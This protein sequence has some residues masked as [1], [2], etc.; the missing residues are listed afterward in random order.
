MNWFK[1]DHEIAFVQWFLID[2]LLFPF[3]GMLRRR[4]DRQ[5]KLGMD[6]ISVAIEAQKTEVRTL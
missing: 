3:L 6:K 2:R 4:G 5:A 1:R